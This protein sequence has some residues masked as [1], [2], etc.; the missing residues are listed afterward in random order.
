MRGGIRAKAVRRL[1]LLF[2]SL[3]SDG[4]SARWKIVNVKSLSLIDNGH[5]Q[6]QTCS[7]SDTAVMVH[8]SAR[9]NIF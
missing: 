1:F 8:V 7:I 5:E 6:D 3:K 2:P 4:E 9:E